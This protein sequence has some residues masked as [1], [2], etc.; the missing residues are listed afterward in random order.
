MWASLREKRPWTEMWGPHKKRND[1]PSPHKK[2][3]S[4]PPNPL[5]FSNLRKYNISRHVGFL[6]SCS[7]C[8]PVP[9]PSNRHDSEEMV[10]LQKCRVLKVL[11]AR[12]HNTHKPGRHKL[13]GTAQA[14]LSLL[15]KVMTIDKRLKK[16]WLLL[17]ESD[18]S[19]V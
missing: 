12:T 17:Q 10:S 8:R 13:C 16:L 9:L 15:M 2:N 6:G 7:W 14:E 18:I 1:K 5:S 4:N 3:N 11:I 19:Q